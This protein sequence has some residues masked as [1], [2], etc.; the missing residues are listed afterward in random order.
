MPLFFVL[1]RGGQ[2]NIRETVN[3]PGVL[4]YC[5]ATDT[6]VNGP[7]QANVRIMPRKKRNFK[8]IRYNQSFINR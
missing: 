8:I 3:D 4:Q 5:Y 2:K 6:R 7:T 1:T